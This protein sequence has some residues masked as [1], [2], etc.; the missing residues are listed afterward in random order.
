M[1]IQV[2]GISEF[3][4]KLNEYQK[5]VSNPKVKT[6]ILAAGGQKVKQ[7]AA[8]A[9]T[10]KSD[11]NKKPFPT[12]PHFYYSKRGK[13]EIISGNL[14]K[15]MKVFRGREGDVYI[16]P[17]FLRSVA[18]LSKIGQTA[19]TSSGYYAHMIYK[20]ASQFRTRIMEAALTKAQ[21]AAL[22]A[23]DKAFTKF[24]NSTGI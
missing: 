19:A 3:N 16:G 11:P 9:P 4:R 5:Q 12:A 10:P 14:R 22:D 15:S 1:S 2:Q 8:K 20:T 7:A 24:H 13:Q 17:R 21:G 6:R 18:G 23:V